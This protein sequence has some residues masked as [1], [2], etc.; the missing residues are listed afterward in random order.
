MTYVLAAWT[1]EFLN[2]VTAS[3]FDVVD[4]RSY[5]SSCFFRRVQRQVYGE[6][7][8]ARADAPAPV[9]EGPNVGR[10]SAVDTGEELSAV[11]IALSY[12]R[13]VDSSKTL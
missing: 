6:P 3:T 7:S 8:P 11:Y 12:I 5:R 9:R 10:L 1:F 13:S 2:Y 4:V